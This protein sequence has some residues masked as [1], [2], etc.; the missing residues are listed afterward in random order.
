MKIIQG[1]NKQGVFKQTWLR[2]CELGEDG[3]ALLDAKGFPIGGY[4]IGGDEDDEDSNLPTTEGLNYL[5][6]LGYNNNDTQEAS[7]YLAI[8]GNNLAPVIGDTAAL[9]AARLGELNAEITN[10]TRPQW[11]PNA[12]NT[13]ASSS[14]SD[15]PAVFTMAANDTIYGAYK[16]SSNTKAGATGV[17]LAAALFDD[18]RSPLA[19]D[20]LQLVYETQLTKTP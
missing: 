20:V 1:L 19:G 2:G 10:V 7:W 15:S 16:I 9:V 13:G 17:L 12:G 8:F 3:Q 18:V 5:A 11:I 6:D 4:V 14:N